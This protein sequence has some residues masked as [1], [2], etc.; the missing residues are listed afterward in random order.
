MHLI[1]LILLCVALAGCA[2][3]NTAFRTYDSKESVMIDVKQ[4]GILSKNH[5]SYPE[6][7][8]VCAE[9]SPDALASYA[10]ELAGSA[11]VKG[12][13]G[14]SSSAATQENAAFVGLRTQSIQL[15]RDA[16]YRLCEGYANGALQEQQFQTLARR[17]QR[18]MVAL[19]AIE[20]MTGTVKVPPVTITTS[21]NASAAQSV[22]VLVEQQSK[23]IEERTA[24]TKA[25][26]DVE[27]TL[28]AKQIEFDALDGTEKPEVKA[29]LEAEIATL[30]AEKKTLGSRIAVLDSAIES[31][32]NAIK[33]PGGY[34]VS[35]TGLAQ[36]HAED[37]NNKISSSD[38][39]AV[40]THVKEIVIGILDNTDDTEE[41]CLDFMKEAASGGVTR[42]VWSTPEL[43]RSADAV[44]TSASEQMLT[45]CTSI[46][47]IQLKAVTR[48][49]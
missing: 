11:D 7:Y 42:V 15:L 37:A 10:A 39:A 34:S 13:V 31:Y 35:G 22:A 23:Y 25:S 28:K 16:L 14:V 46:L 21:G 40:A 18:N 32:A 17:Y 41:M 43:Q 2:K 8:V 12:E 9:P 5:P 1:G 29:K 19:L 27:N 38:R 3:F 4:R 24:K 30:T 33:S 48:A 47:S 36:V 26:A 20:Q 45:F 44:Q 6:R 49:N